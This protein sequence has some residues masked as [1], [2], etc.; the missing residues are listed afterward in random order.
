MKLCAEIA[1]EFRVYLVVL[2]QTHLTVGAD[3]VD[4]AV[5]RGDALVEAFDV[6][7]EAAIEAGA[8]VTDAVTYRDKAVAHLEAA[9]ASVVGV[10]DEV[11]MVIFFLYNVGFGQTVITDTRAAVRGV[12]SEIKEGIAD[13]QT[14]IEKLREAL[15]AIGED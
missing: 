4:L 12:H 7:V 14:A 5:D 3:R 15:D 6:A 8:D 1:I 13:G 2:P 10:A 9:E 11:L